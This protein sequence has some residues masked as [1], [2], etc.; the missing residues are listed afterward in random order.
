M[1]HQRDQFYALLLFKNNQYRVNHNAA[2]C[3]C[4]DRSRATSI[5]HQAQ[6]LPAAHVIIV[7]GRLYNSSR[8]SSLTDLQVITLVSPFGR[9][10]LLALSRPQDLKIYR[11]G[12]V[13]NV[14]QA[15]M[16]CKFLTLARFLKRTFKYGMKPEQDW[17]I[18]YFLYAVYPSHRTPCATVTARSVYTSFF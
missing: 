1:R 2:S 16:V 3:P 11:L 4:H 15:R 9:M 6:T 12:R 18:P 13:N 7:L 5:S 10:Y 8:L 17:I 14:K